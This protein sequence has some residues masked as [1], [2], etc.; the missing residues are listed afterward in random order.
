LYGS[1]TFRSRSDTLDISGVPGTGKTATV[2]SVVVELKRLL[3]NEELAPFEYLEMNGMKLSDP[4]QAYSI[5]YEKL[6]KKNVSPSHAASLLDKYFSA[7]RR[8]IP[9][10]VV[11]RFLLD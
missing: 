4:S 11:S 9:L 2:Q 6:T 7:K 5:L 1:I 10:Y 3:E 8:K